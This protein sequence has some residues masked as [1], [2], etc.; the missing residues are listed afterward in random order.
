ML[1]LCMK[2]GGGDSGWEGGM[3]RGERV[4]DIQRVRISD[5]GVNHV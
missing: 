1:R 3:R 2:Y 4:G 5:V